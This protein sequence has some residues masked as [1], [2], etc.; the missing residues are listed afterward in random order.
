MDPDERLLTGALLDSAERVELERMTAR[1]QMDAWAR[2]EAEAELM[3]AIAE[4]TR[5]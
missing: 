1:A 2:L 4:R 5:V 3:A